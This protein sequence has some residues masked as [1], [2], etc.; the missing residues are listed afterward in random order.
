MTTTLSTTQ[1]K[2]PFWKRIV[3]YHFPLLLYAGVIFYLSSIPSVKAPVQLPAGVDKLAH[4]VEYA[5]FALIVF[6]SF[7]DFLGSRS[8]RLVVMIGAIF[9]LIFAAMDEL[10]QGTIPGRNQDPLDLTADFVGGV[11]VL[12]LLGLRARRRKASESLK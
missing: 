2:P 8:I 7:N 12:I 10:F 11:A 4:F 9:I 6:R 5:L 1:P 3:L